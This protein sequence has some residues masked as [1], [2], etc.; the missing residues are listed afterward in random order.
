[1]KQRKTKISRELCE[2]GARGLSGR[3]RPAVMRTRLT[4]SRAG[5]RQHPERQVGHPPCM[6]FTERLPS[7][8]P[9]LPIR[10]WVKVTKDHHLRAPGATGV[11]PLGKSRA[12]R[13]HGRIGRSS[14][15]GDRPIP[16][17]SHYPTCSYLVQHY[18]SSRHT[19]SALD[20]RLKLPRGRG[21]L[22]LMEFFDRSDRRRAPLLDQSRRCSL[23][24]AESRT[25]GG[26]FRVFPTRSSRLM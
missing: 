23:R 19:S 15:L 9:A 12:R 7:P 3:E 21:L 1:M 16:P 6:A 10:G 4:E 11:L 8:A 5:Q 25:V 18:G 20:S 17:G 14:L 24:S 2:S 22:L 13:P 26:L